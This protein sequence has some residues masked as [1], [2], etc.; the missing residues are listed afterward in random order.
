MCGS[1]GWVERRVSRCLMSWSVVSERLGMKL[2]MWPVGMKCLAEVRR[3]L[4]NWVSP[5]LAQEGGSRRANA[6]SVSRVNDSQSAFLKLV[7][8]MRG[9]WGDSEEKVP[10]RWM[11]MGR[12]SELR[13]V[14][15]VHSKSVTISGVD[16]ERSGE[17]G[18]PWVGR[19]VG[20]SRLRRIRLAEVRH[21]GSPPHG[22]PRRHC[23]FAS[24]TRSCGH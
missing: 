20:V 18:F 16:M 8:E 12:W 5:V 2:G 6:S 3:I 10:P 19:W 24:T 23:W 17:V 13:V 4:R 7:N 21:R 22:P 9:S 15:V 11:S 14:R 1:E